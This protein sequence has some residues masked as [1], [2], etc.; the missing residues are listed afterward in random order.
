MGDEALK[1]S[2]GDTEWP[3]HLHVLR[4]ASLLPSHH[5]TVPITLTL[6]VNQPRGIAFYEL[7]LLLKQL[8]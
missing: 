6:P 7:N 8:Q 1:S 4:E 2:C 3:H 5:P